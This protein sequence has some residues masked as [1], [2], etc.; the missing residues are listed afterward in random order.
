MARAHPEIERW[1]HQQR[2]V[3]EVLNAFKDEDLRRVLLSGP[4]GSG[5]SLQI[6]D[7]TTEFR[8]LGLRTC[9]FTNRKMLVDQL[10]DAFVAARI[11]HGVRAAGYEP[12]LDAMVQISSMQTES[13]RTL[14]RKTWNLDGISLGIVDEAHLHN[15]DTGNAVTK[16]I[17]EQG[18]YILGVSATPLGLKD[19]YDRL[20]VAGTNSECRRNGALVKADHYGPDEPDIE[21]IKDLRAKIE[22]GATVSE[23][24]SAAA[25]QLPS[26]IGRIGEWFD[27]LNPKRLPTVAFG[28][29]VAGSMFIAEQFTK[30]GVPFAHIDGD[31]VWVDGEL[32]PNSPTL[33]EEVIRRHREGDLIGL[34]TRFVL[35]EGVDLKWIRHM[36]FATIFG[37]IQTYI[38]SGGRGLRADDYA[39]TI[40]RFGP[41]TCCTVQDH[42]G[43]WWKYG[44]LNEDRLWQIDDTVSA[45]VGERFARIRHQKDDEPRV[46]PN[47]SRVIKGRVCPCGQVLG[48]KRSRPIISADGELR[49]IEGPI[50]KPRRISTL[51]NGEADWIA[52]YNRGRHYRVERAEIDGVLF[53][54]EKGWKANFAQLIGLYAHEHD[55]FFPNPTWRFMPRNERDYYRLVV[56]VP[57]ERLY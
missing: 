19:Q 47:C 39:D 17:L 34:S 40:E 38:Q 1:S 14:K 28:P 8:D 15:N 2:G 41:K 45:I 57:P 7:V 32:R 49:H 21:A 26:I 37:S 6:L 20:I 51:P 30:R 53:D 27:K 10:V 9:I 50:I 23:R 33:R 3:A 43:N 13:S 35:R 24:K 4:T 12:D 54:I 22:A 31:D 44:S 52:T 46:C 55:G 25:M 16:L 36:I 11:P 18:G 5:K 56:D 48:E 29:D 42:G